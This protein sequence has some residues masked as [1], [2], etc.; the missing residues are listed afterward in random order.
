MMGGG[1]AYVFV[2][3]LI[4][5]KVIGGSVLRVFGNPLKK[6]YQ[7]KLGGKIYFEK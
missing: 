2:S 6:I 5:A 1:Y 7:K 3:E 4:D